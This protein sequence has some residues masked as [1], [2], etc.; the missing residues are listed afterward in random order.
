MKTK[1]MIMMAMLGVAFT[2][3]FTT[4]CTKQSSGGFGL[5]GS[6]GILSQLPLDVTRLTSESDQLYG[7]LLALNAAG[8]VSTNDMTAIS[9]DYLRYREIFNIVAPL[10]RRN[11]P[12]PPEL[13]A[14]ADQFKTTANTAKAK[15]AKKK[16]ASLPRMGEGGEVVKAQ[17]TEDGGRRTAARQQPSYRAFADFAPSRDT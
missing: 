1:L 3:T 15:A 6:D 17:R 14:A 5:F 9:E 11:D 16:T 4:G 10:L 12:V 8:H 13:A 2:L 7:M